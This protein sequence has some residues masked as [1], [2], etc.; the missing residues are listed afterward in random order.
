[1]PRQSQRGLGAVRFRA[2]CG[3]GRRGNGGAPGAI[4]CTGDGRGARD[5]QG[6]EGHGGQVQAPEELSASPWTPAD[7]AS[8]PH[9][10]HRGVV[11]WR[12]R[13]AL[14]ARE[15]VATPIRRCSGSSGLAASS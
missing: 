12:T 15:T 8:G 14:V 2:V 6:T 5:A 13:K 1:A 7:D 4:V 9:G 11:S 10:E 3:K